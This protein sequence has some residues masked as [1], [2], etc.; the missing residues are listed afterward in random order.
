MRSSWGPKHLRWLADV[1]CPTPAQQIVFQEYVQTINERQLRVERIERELLDHAKT[2][3]LYPVVLAIQAMRGIRFTVAITV[4]AE[5]GD[6]TRFDDPRQLMAYLGVT[7]T[8]YSSGSKRRL[9]S[10]TKTGNTHARRVLVEGAWAYRFPAKVSRE[11][12]RR[13][14][15]LPPSIQAIAWKAQ[16]RLCKRYHR[17]VAKGKD[18]NIVVVAI[19]REMIAFVWAIAKQTPIVVEG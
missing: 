8:E 16:L 5:L 15:D 7:P 1:V 13:Q 4:I 17:L 19:A 6:L 2:W 14:E 10:I 12:Q 3:R 18:K 9:G 11:I